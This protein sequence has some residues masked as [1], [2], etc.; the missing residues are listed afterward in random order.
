MQCYLR[1]MELRA[2]KIFSAALVM[3]AVALGAG[4]GK[5][6]QSGGS[7]AA[8][9]DYPL[10]KN[11][12]LSECETGV[13]G[14]RLVITDFAGPKT[15]NPVTANE[16]SS[17]NIIRLIFSG[18]TTIDAPTQ[19]VLPALA[20]SWSVDSDKKTWTLKLRQGVRWSDGEPFTAD[21]VVFTWNDLVYNPDIVNVTVDAFRINGKDFTISKVDEFTV[22][23]VTPE[24]YAPFLENFGTRQILPKHILAKEVASKRFEAAYGVNWSPNQIVG[25]GPFR[26]KQFKPGEY[27]LL[28]RNPYFWM[29]DSKGTRLPYLDMVVYSVVPDWNT[30]SLR[31]LKGESNVYERVRPD[32][33]DRFKQEEASGRFKVVDLGIGTETLFFC[34]N[35][36]TNINSKTGRPHVDQKKL[37]W[38]RN[39]KFR[40]AMSY[41]VDR[42]SISRSIYS[43]R[44]KPNYG[45]VTEA[46][47]KWFNPTI[48][49]FPY[50]PRK[51]KALLAEIGIQDRNGDGLL[52]DADGNIIEFVF[53]T[54]TGNNIRD[55]MAVL[56]QDDLK[57]LGIKLIYQPIEFNALIDK[58]QTSFDFDC[59][60]LSMAPSANDP[61]DP[62]SS[63]NVLRSEGF[64]HQWFPRQKKPSTDWEARIDE[65][66][67]TNLKTLDVAERKK[68]FDEVQAILSDQVPFIYTVSPLSYAAYSS[69]LG[70]VRPTV[71][72]YYRVTWNIEE[73]YFKK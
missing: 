62:S 28:E 53:N 45:Y 11:P 17:E 57:K 56:I 29:V 51:A 16:G 35:Q 65:L 14:G 6:G 2:A 48:R 7:S 9:G 19:K 20:E 15:F 50:D 30:M 59:F 61:L 54:N 18:L 46:N 26:I 21:D 10:P 47:F 39:T 31:M 13:R 40:Q 23:V 69:K 3:S 52:E 66:M 70:N 49:Q 64:T 38:F 37:K 1:T 73:L 4:C 63:L 41:A 67:D 27:T 25:S 60:L 71:L 68:T 72:H 55:R 34:F 33:L 42:E 22:R 5:S 36:N 8:K 32:E 58:L 12:A 24:A 43:G 44:A